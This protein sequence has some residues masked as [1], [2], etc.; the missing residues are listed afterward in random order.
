MHVPVIGVGPLDVDY[1]DKLI[2]LVMYSLLVCLGGR[3]W[4]GTGRAVT[5]ATL[6]AH[7]GM[8]AAY[9]AFDEWSQQ[10][11]GR[12]MSLSDWLADAAGIAL[13]TLWLIFRQ[14]QMRSQTL[15]HKPNRIE[16]VTLD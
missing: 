14:R 3:Y 16:N 2:H 15:A 5:T 1:A 8:Y 6:I 10:F 4:I 7:A 11:V 9:A 12:T 13:A